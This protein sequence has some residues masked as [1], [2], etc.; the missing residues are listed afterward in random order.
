MMKFLLE[1]LSQNGRN[2]PNFPLE[3]FSYG[4]PPIRDF[5]VE[6]VTYIYNLLDLDAGVDLVSPPTLSNRFFIS[7]KRWGLEL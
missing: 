5:S 4:L 6:Q 7:S 1:P 2:R 3:Q